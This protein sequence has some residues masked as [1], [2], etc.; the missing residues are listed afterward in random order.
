MSAVSV[1]PDAELLISGHLDEVLDATVGTKVPN[2]RPS[3]LVVVRR[4]GGPRLNPVADD[5]LLTIE[6]WAADPSDAHDL[7]QLARAHVHALRGQVVAGAAVYRTADA[8]GPQS[9]PDPLSDEPRY[10][11]TVSVALR[12]AA[13]DPGS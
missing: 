10:S 13:L 4:V 7:A 6:S 2:P 5:A 12:G 9:L 1:F 3:P 11:F 8:A